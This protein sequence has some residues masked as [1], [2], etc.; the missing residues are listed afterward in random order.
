MPSASLSQLEP[1][2]LRLRPACGE[3]ERKGEESETLQFVSGCAFL[4]RQLQAECV[5]N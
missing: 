5:Q 4:D 3:E 1:L 2:H